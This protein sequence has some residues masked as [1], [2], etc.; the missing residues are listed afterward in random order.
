MQPV[1]FTT[2]YTDQAKQYFSPAFAGTRTYIPSKHMQK[3]VVKKLPLF[4]KLNVFL[5]KNSNEIL[6]AVITALGTAFIAPIFIAFNPLSKEDDD[7]KKYSAL[8]Q[9]IS[10]VIAVITQISVNLKFDKWIDKLAR[11]GELTSIN[12]KAKPNEALLRKQIIAENEQKIVKARANNM[13]EAEIAK[14]YPKLTEYDIQEAVDDR[15]ES[16]FR[17]EVEVQRNN[18]ENKNIKLN[19]LV[20]PDTYKDHRKKIMDKLKEEGKKVSSS[21]LARLTEESV[22]AELE[23]KY[24]KDKIEIIK[25]LIAEKEKEGKVTHKERIAIFEK[26]EHEIQ[27]EKAK[28]LVRVAITNAE[29]RLKNFKKYSGIAL[30]LL[31]LPVS[32][33]VLNWSYPRFV[34]KFMPELIADKKAKE[35]K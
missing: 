15:V 11:S 22:V 12:L 28:K 33:S 4:P 35:N 24:E 9:P 25:N 19:D 13:S 2:K 32:C 7:T 29:E 8:R 31:C 10:A 34:E 27:A 5:G 23:K 3:E 18:P 26:A 20:C 17:A 14:K 1:S 16:D 30:A 21:E 6:S